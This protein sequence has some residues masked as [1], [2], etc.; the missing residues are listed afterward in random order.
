ME[1]GSTTILMVIS[2]LENGKTISL[3]GTGFTYSKMEKDSMEY[4]IKDRR[5]DKVNIFI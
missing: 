1:R 5:M 3:K 2:M 4:C